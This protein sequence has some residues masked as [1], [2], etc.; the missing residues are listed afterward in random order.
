MLLV[1][2]GTGAVLTAVAGARRA[3]TAYARFLRDSL[4]ADYRLQYS[5][6]KGTD[7]VVMDRLHHDP[8]VEA[9]V[10]VSFTVASSDASEYTRVLPQ[11]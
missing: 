1:G 11:P 9:A 7:T 4:A 8:A 2:L 5:S 3:D 6:D 10:A